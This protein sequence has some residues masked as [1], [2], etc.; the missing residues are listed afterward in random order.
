MDREDRAN[1]VV[2]PPVALALCVGTGWVADRVWPSPFVRT[3]WP[4]GW[5]G[6][7]LIALALLIEFWALILF[8]R[9]RTAIIPT[10]PTSAIVETGPYR[11]SRNPIYVGMFLTVVG[12]AFVLD[13]LWQL[14]ALAV[15]YLVVRWGVVAREEAY[16][17]RK[18]GA[19]YLD[20]AKRVRRERRQREQVR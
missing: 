8:R 15:L 2:L 4:R 1:V 12:A 10:R 19:A 16:L 17:A 18:F 20:Y 14:A 11:Y 7:A 9:A 5:V 13:S 3:V 6:G